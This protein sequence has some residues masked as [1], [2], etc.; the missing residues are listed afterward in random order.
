MITYPTEANLELRTNRKRAIKLDLINNQDIKVA[1]FLK[2]IGVKYEVYRCTEGASDTNDDYTWQHDKF[3]IQLSRKD[4]PSQD[5]EF[6]TGLG[7]RIESYSSLGKNARIRKFVYNEIL[8][9]R[10]GIVFRKAN[11]PVYS[12]Y[13]RPKDRFKTGQII[14]APTQASFLSCMLMDGQ[15]IDTSFKSWC[16]EFGF[17][18]DSM[19][20]FRM[21]E[22]CCEIGEKLRKIFSNQEIQR[23]NELLQDY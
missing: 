18:S 17:N 5:F 12:H 16:D 11:V 7:H 2:L 9:I 10:E 6:K 3:D 23:L 14:K 15:A 20:H 13:N 21:Y 8:N 4:K 19:K 22:Y 1:R